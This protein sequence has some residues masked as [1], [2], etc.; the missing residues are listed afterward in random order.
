MAMRFPEL[1]QKQERALGQRDVTI[2]IAFAT[3]DVEEPAFGINVADLEAQPFAQTQATGVDRG[4]GN[5]M[6]QGGNGGEDAAGFGGGQDDR[7]FELGIG[8]DQ[9]QFVRPNPFERLFPEQFEGADDLGG[10]LAGELLFGLEMDA[11]LAELLGG[12]QV[13]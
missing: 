1:A 10:S 8:T 5:A 9:F 3:P 11:I 12:D 6:I 7:Q 13:G 2:L 4:Q